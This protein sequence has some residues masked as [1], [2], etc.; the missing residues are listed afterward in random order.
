MTGVFHTSPVQLGVSI[1]PSYPNKR[2]T[3]V[4]KG[5]EGRGVGMGCP[6][7]QVGERSK[8]PQPQTFLAQFCAM[9]RSF[10]AFNSCLEMG[11]SYISLF[12]G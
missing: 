5:V 9:S 11:D 7:L 8:L 12:T 2:S 6:P 4:V 1:F 3:T 10:S